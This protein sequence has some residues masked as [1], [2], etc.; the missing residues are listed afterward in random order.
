MEKSRFRNQMMRSLFV[1]LAASLVLMS[2]NCILAQK[3]PASEALGILTLWYDTPAAFCVLANDFQAKYRTLLN[4]A[5]PIG[6]GRM[7]ALIKGGVAKEFIPL[8]E[9]SLWT[10]SSNP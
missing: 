1:V 2:Q 6:N 4:T 3:A 9:D 10:G 7:G 5:L 8:N